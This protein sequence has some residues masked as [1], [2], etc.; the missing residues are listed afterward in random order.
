M[1]DEYDDAP[2]PFHDKGLSLTEQFYQ[3]KQLPY[4][5]QSAT[6]S[7]NDNKID[8]YTNK[9]ATLKEE[10]AQEDPGSVMDL[11]EEPWI[12][13][14]EEDDEDHRD[15]NDVECESHESIH[16]ANGDTASTTP[17]STKHFKNGTCSR[18]SS[19]AKA[20]RDRNKYLN[21]NDRH[22]YKKLRKAID[23]GQLNDSI[24]ATP[25]INHHM[26]NLD[27]LEPLNYLTRPVR[28]FIPHLQYNE[29]PKSPCGCLDGHVVRDGWKR[30]FIPIFSFSRTEDYYL[31]MPA[32]YTCTTCSHS[33]NADDAYCMSNYSDKV[34]VNLHFY[35]SDRFGVDRGI[36]KRITESFVS[37]GADKIANTFKEESLEH[38]TRQQLGR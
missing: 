11:D 14:L 13:D 26:L 3:H 35:L 1:L 12:V 32:R 31:L 7:D 19:K 23:G 15:K 25:L 22:Y 17:D 16:S 18:A 36:Y 21:D 37:D 33:F 24:F 38:Y 27:S 20:T 30:S 10:M 8:D 34:K 5:R 4:A 28:I 9:M 6:S 2:Q 29:Y